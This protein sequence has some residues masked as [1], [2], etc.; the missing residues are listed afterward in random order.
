MSKL[1]DSIRQITTHPI[2]KHTILLTLIIFSLVFI[3][4]I[5]LF[6]SRTIRPLRSPIESSSHDITILQYFPSIEQGHDDWQK[7]GRNIRSYSEG[8]LRKYCEARGYR[9]VRSLAGYLSEDKG[10]DESLVVL[11]SALEMLER[12]DGREKWLI[13][14]SPQSVI[15]NPLIPLHSYLPPTSNNG[16]LIIS[17]DLKDSTLILRINDQT[18]EIILDVIQ[19]TR[20]EQDR[21]ERSFREVLS[22]YINSYDGLREKVQ[23]IPQ[24]WFD[25]TDLPEIKPTDHI[26]IPL[27]Y[28]FPDEFMI[29]RSK[30]QIQD[31]LAIPRRIYDQTE[32]YEKDMLRFYGKLVNGLD[33]Q[34]VKGETEKIG[35]SWWTRI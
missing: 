23:S 5:G 9:Y 24:E 7:E 3:H 35:E 2:L 21:S 27:I 28:H 8:S 25:S 33:D 26:Q 22:G 17:S 34:E 18:M 12:R 31:V 6:P 19:L 14:I 11:K 4:I 32:K 16:P 20:S 1:F 15:I 30:R 10:R 29:Y 13:W